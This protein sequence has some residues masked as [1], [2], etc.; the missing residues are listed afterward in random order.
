[1]VALL[2]PLQPGQSDMAKVTIVGV[3]YVDTNKDQIDVFEIC[4]GNDRR[5]VTPEQ[6]ASLFQE[7]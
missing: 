4:V 1:M 6:L 5:F 7:V 2:K 3:L